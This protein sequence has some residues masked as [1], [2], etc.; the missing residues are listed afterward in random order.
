LK[1]GVGKSTSCANLAY[2]LAKH[3]KILVIDFD[4]QGG[5]T[6]HLSSKFSNFK[7]SLYDV[8]KG[9]TGIEYA[10]HNYSKNLDLIP[11]SY[12][13]YEM[14]AINFEDKLQA[15]ID[16]IKDRY[17]FLFF[18]L[19]PSI[20]PGTEIPLLMS[21]F[22]IIPVDCN[23]ALS[24]LGL[25]N[26][27]KIIGEL[28]KDKKNTDL[29]LLGILPTFVDRTRV[30]KD[31]LEFLQ[32]KYKDYVLTYIRKNTALAQASSLGKTIFEHQAK[33]NGAKDYLELSKEFL[34]RTKKGK[35]A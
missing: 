33:S 30:S 5:L 7:A 25:Q 8:L 15:A 14:A 20:Y 12:K 17:D 1:G 29:D 16:E 11:I 13:F 18:D 21:N 23:G 34:K 3:Y 27:E 24:I 6:H 28:S 2:I 9:K 32:S 22:V 31:V 35:E 4:A 26:V 19:A 10:V